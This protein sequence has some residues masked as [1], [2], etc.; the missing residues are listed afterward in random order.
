M[1]ATPVLASMMVGMVLVGLACAA[2]GVA[3]RAD[4]AG[5]PPAVQATPPAA[6]AARIPDPHTDPRALEQAVLDA[7]LAFLRED[8]AAARAALDRVEAG[9]QRLAD[10]DEAAPELR[11][12]DRG[13]HSAVDIARELATR[14]NID[15]SFHHFTWVQRGCRSCHRLARE[16]RDRVLHGDDRPVG[17]PAE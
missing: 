11:T 10:R 8:A 17:R 16:E 4:E 1:S 9:C 5:R 15:E 13:F 12:Y 2:G 7:T 6:V 3:S 14:G